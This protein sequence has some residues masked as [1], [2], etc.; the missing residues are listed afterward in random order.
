MFNV[1]L[2]KLISIAS[3]GAGISQEIYAFFTCAR[4]PFCL[5]WQQVVVEIFY[6]FNGFKLIHIRIINVV[7]REAPPQPSVFADINGAVAFKIQSDIIDLKRSQ[8]LPGEHA[9]NKSA[10]KADG[11]V[12]F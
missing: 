6:L 12:F 1:T 5:F 2:Y 7:K 10:V 4:Y 3:S 8:L 9:H 11:Y